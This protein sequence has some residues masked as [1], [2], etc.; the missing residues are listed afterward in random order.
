LE[1]DICVQ[2]RTV[3][4]VKSAFD[5]AGFANA[6]V[7]VELGM[8]PLENIAPAPQKFWDL[9]RRATLT[10]TAPP[11]PMRVPRQASLP[12]FKLIEQYA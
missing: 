4:E 8:E 9:Y 10:V 7:A 12:R 5:Q 11:I 1:Y 2:G 3:E 6:M